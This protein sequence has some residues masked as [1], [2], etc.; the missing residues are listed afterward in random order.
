[1]SIKSIVAL[2]ISAAF[3]AQVIANDEPG[4]LHKVF[5]EVDGLGIIHSPEFPKDGKGPCYFPY[6]TVAVSWDGKVSPC[7]LYYDYQIDL[8]SLDEKTFNEIWNGEAYK[9]FRIMLKDMNHQTLAFIIGVNLFLR[10]PL[11]HSHVNHIWLMIIC[12]SI[13]LNLL[14]ETLHCIHIR[15]KESR[16]GLL[17]KDI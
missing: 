15:C 12:F 17:M 8:G 10:I 2:V 13:V 11:L 14:M 4:G 6:Y 3:S 1:M 5:T 7:C 9:N 16:I